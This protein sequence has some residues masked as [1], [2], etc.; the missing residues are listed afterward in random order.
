M[1]SVK[2]NQH[3]KYLGQRSYSSTQ[4]HRHLTECSTCTINVVG[5]NFTKK[6]I[7]DRQ[8]DKMTKGKIITLAIEVTI[9]TAITLCDSASVIR[10]NF[11]FQMSNK[12]A[13]VSNGR[14]FSSVILNN[15]KIINKRTT[16]V[17]AAADRP[18]WHS[19]SAHAKYSVSH[20]M[21]IKP[22]LLLGLAAEYRSGQLVWLTVVRRPSEVYDTHLRT[23]L[24]APEMINHS[25]DM[26]GPTKILKACVT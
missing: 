7:T 26:V 2:V 11:D 9:L 22:F 18:T 12:P 23:K 14:H 19:G 15:S 24:T 6:L 16:R 4:T 5:D 13:I 3:A 25:R 20:H 17:S 10:T 21:I 1:H 8:T